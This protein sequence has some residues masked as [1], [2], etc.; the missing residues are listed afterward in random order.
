[1]QGS[2]PSSPTLYPDLN[3]VLDDLTRSVAAI[4]CDNFYGACLQGSFALGDFD[5][6]SDADFLI[7]INGDL[8]VAQLDALQAMHGRLYA[9]QCAWAQHLEGSYIRKDVLRD[10]AAAGS[11]VWFLDHGSRSLV[12]SPHCNSIVVRCVVRDYGIRLAG[13]DPRSLVDPIPPTILRKE[14][15]G[16]MCNWGGISLLADPAQIDSLWYQSFVVVVYCRMLYTLDTGKIGS[17]L[18]SVRWA[19][20]ALDARWAGLIERAW[21]QRPDPA[22]KSRQPV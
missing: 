6:H 8:A 19:V 7:V 17:K 12:R 1:M 13:P 22:L 11:D 15:L 21:A 14:V 9:G 4:L 3:A 2:S 16:T 20:D 5:Q 18:T 10:P